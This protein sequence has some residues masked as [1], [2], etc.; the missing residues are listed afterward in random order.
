M[1]IYFASGTYIFFKCCFLQ[2]LRKHFYYLNTTNL[3][4]NLLGRL[5]IGSFEYLTPVLPLYTFQAIQT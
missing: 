2:E 3:C 1:L 4:E 5:K